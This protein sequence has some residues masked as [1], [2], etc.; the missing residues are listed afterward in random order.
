RVGVFAL[1]Y[2]LFV[3]G[4]SP[5]LELIGYVMLVVLALTGSLE[6]QFAMAFLALAVVY[7]M[8]VGLGSA[9]LDLTLPHSP[10]RLEDRI[11]LLNAVVTE[12]LWYRPW[13]AYVRVVAMFRIRSSR[14]KW[15]QMVRE[16]FS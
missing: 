14:G 10:K 5:V 7:G 13:L 11:R 6:F 8:L 2:A 9:A 1:P 16:R 4:L 12:T 15:G 3:E